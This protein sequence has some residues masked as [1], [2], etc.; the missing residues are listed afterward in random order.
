[1]T[2][3]SFVPQREGLSTVSTASPPVVV[4]ETNTSSSER[5][6][7]GEEVEV[8]VDEVI[9]LEDGEEGDKLT[10][11][12]AILFFVSMKGKIDQKA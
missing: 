12:G 5:V 11:G 10:R 8:V 1:M 3:V 7:D 9:V 6:E 2:N 4:P